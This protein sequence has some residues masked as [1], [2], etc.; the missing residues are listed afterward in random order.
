MRRY[1][2][3]QC[4]YGPLRWIALTMKPKRKKL[5]LMAVADEEFAGVGF[6]RG[7]RRCC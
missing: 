4:G 5:V 2:R 6:R 1:Q 7:L 3:S